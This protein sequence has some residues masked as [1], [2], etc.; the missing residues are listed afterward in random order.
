MRIAV[1]PGL[2]SKTTGTCV[3]P[4]GLA[5]LLTL[6]GGGGSSGAPI[7][8]P[9]PVNTVPACIPANRHGHE[10]NGMSLNY[11]KPYGPLTYSAAL[12]RG[13][14]SLR[15]RIVPESEEEKR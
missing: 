3:I 14:R 12:A 4:L 2:S 9:P 10:R 7:L 11:A 6:A 5:C 13:V 15:N 8:A 1:V